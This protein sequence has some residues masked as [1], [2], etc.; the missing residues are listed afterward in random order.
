MST[1]VYLA[2]IG[3]VQSLSA[4]DA[5]RLI[6]A[7]RAAEVA[8]TAAEAEAFKVNV[9]A[10]TEAAVT[11]VAAAGKAAEGVA[12]LSAAKRAEA[13]AASARREEEAEERR[14]RRSSVFQREPTAK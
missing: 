8:R 14:A 12:A 5:E 7:V 11:V 3:K 9:S 6:N 2:I 4:A 1:Q 10:C 13:A